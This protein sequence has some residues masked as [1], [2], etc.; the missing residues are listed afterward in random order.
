[1]PLQI[2]NEVN[3][4]THEMLTM[5][6]EFFEQ[7]MVPAISR[8]QI[9]AIHAQLHLTKKDIEDIL[10]SAVSSESTA[11]VS[12]QCTTDSNYAPNIASVSVACPGL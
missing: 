4:L 12:I 6:W 9:A 5:M 3:I 10:C 2:L 1:M 7:N 8:Y 11:K